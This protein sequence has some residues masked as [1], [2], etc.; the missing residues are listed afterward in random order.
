MTPVSVQQQSVETFVLSMGLPENHEILPY[1]LYVLG[2]P[3]TN[4]L[5]L[6]R[7]E[8]LDAAML[9]RQTHAT[10]RQVI[11]AMTRRHPTVLILE[12]L[13]WVDAASRSFL[14][15]LVQTTDQA[16]LL[17]LFVSRAAE[18]QTVLKPFITQAIHHPEQWLDLQLEPLALQETWH[19]VDQLISHS[20][21]EAQRLKQKII[22]RAEGNP[23][24]VEEIVQML[25]DQK[26]LQRSPQNGRWQV[27]GYAADLLRTIPGTVKGLLLA[28]V[29]GLPEGMRRTLQQA[30][31]FG[32]DFATEVLL[33]IGDLSPE[34][35]VAQLNELESRQFLL[36]RSFRSAP[37]Y[38]FQHKL[39]QETIYNTLVK[40]DRQKIHT[41]A[42]HIIE[43][44]KLWLPDEQAEVLA[45]HYAESAEPFKAIPHLMIAG[46]IAL[47]RCAYETAIHHYRQV[48]RLLP[49][50]PADQFQAEYFEGCIGL[51]TALKFTGA[52]TEANQLFSEMLLNLWY[53]NLSA[54]PTNLEP[55]LIESLRQMADIQQRSG[56][57]DQALNYLQA[58]LQLLS[59]SDSRPGPVARLALLDRIAWVHFR[60]GK[61]EKALSVAQAAVEGITPRATNSTISLASLH[62]TLGGVAWQQNDLTKAITHVKQSLRLYDDLG[63][64]YGV[65]VAYGNLG[66]LHSQQGSWH[67][68]IRYYERAYAGHQMIGNR[69]GLAVS[70]DNR[71]LLFLAMGQLDQARTDLDE[72]LVIRQQMGDTWGIAQTH[73]NLAQ[74]TLT[75]ANFEAA[76]HHASQALLISQSIDSVEIKAESSWISALVHAEYGRLAEGLQI[77]E[78]ALTLS[79][80]AGLSQQEAQSLRIMGSLHRRLDNFA[81]AETLLEQALEI[82][83]TRND[84]YLQGQIL[85]EFGQLY[86]DR[87]AQLAESCFEKATLQFEK[88]GA[89]WYLHAIRTAMGQ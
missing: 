33:G 73:A 35:I 87:A 88:L 25:I 64:L 41:M 18:R 49:S 26:G 59:E 47:R 51:A 10:L 54:N 68:A 40:R 34:V 62:N 15:Y 76:E 16:S 44:S 66:I 36:S 4:P 21:S 53:S 65:A 70:L 63:Y 72:A 45:Y 28:R 48:K 81:E 30:A 83:K 75:Q 8:A 22:E 61:L 77:A 38:S 3:Q 20:S 27:T 60:Q 1:L 5:H 2:L 42:A 86:Q 56:A 57:F 37:G 79:R 29:D 13:Q 9:Q 50:R 52:L 58:G 32:A 39:M 46:D 43:Q 24:F 78:Q 85:M 11:L 80:E 67:K 69:D 31:V 7:L 82:S 84:P 55:I 71:G 74:V 17:L 14:E 89:N 6:A 12:D 19:L 23:L